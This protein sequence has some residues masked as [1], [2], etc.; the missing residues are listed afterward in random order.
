VCNLDN[1]LYQV[2]F[3][4]M[5]QSSSNLIPFNVGDTSRMKSSFMSGYVWNM[6]GIITSRE[7]TICMYMLQVQ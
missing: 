6:V 5:P 2:V 4:R 7:K 3:G 1:V